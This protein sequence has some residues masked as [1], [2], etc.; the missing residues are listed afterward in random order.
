MKILVIEDDMNK[1]QN[2]N[3]VLSEKNHKITECYSYNSG[4][5]A[6]I[7]NYYDLLVLDMS[8]PTFDIKSSENGGRPKPFAGKEILR[9]LG[10]RQIKLKV[11]VVTQFEMFGDSQSPISLETLNNE[12]REKYSSNY[13]GTVYY[14]S[15]EKRWEN[16]FLDILNG[17]GQDGKN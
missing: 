17:I 2:I 1:L 7:A 9:Q 11:I 6:I 12:L 13:I 5:K 16:Q 8:L 4:L 10:R 3:K 14:E 15:S